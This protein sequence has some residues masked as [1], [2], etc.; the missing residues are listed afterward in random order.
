M[1]YKFTY[2][3][4]LLGLTTVVAWADGKNQGPEIDTRVAMILEEG[5]TNDEFNS[6][7]KKYDE[8]NS[9]EF[10]FQQSIKGLLKLTKEEQAKAIAWMWEIANVSTPDEEEMI[11]LSQLE[12]VENWQKHPDYVDLEELVWINRAKKEL[13]LSVAEIKVAFALLPAAKRI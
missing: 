5:I 8:I 6:F 13:N 9:L 11:D 10:T 2:K 1:E 7:K 12:T 4:A 3:D